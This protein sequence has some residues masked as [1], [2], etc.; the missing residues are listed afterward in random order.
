[1]P[2]I[3]LKAKIS[4]YVF[5]KLE[6][7]KAIFKSY[8]VSEHMLF[9]SKICHQRNLSALIFRP[10]LQAFYLFNFKGS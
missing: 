4:L 8:T 6:E 2:L 5:G 1:M 3:L 10:W 7:Y 9:W